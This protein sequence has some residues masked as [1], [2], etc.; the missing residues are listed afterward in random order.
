MNGWTVLG[1]FSFLILISFFLVFSLYN[2]VEREKKAFWRSALFLA[3]LVFVNFGLRL[4]EAPLQ[5]WLFGAVFTLFTF[6]LILLLVP[7]LKKRTVEIVGEPQKIDERDVI[8][9]RFDL[10]EGTE[11]FEGYYER[12]PEYKKIDDEIRKIPDILAS[13]HFDKN[14]EL[15]SLAA[16]EFDF[17]EQQ[18]TQVRGEV[19]ERMTRSSPAENTRLV[20]K[21]IKYLGGDICGV[22]LLDQAY[23]YSH[24]GRGPE[25]YGQKINV[26]H[27]YAIAF[28]LEMDLGMIAS[29]PRVPVIV[30]TGRKY[31]E[32]AKISITVA[33]LIR[34]LGFPARAHIAGSNYQVM[35]P[36]FG[37]KGGLGELGRLGILITEKYGP[38][39]RLGLI[40]TDFPLIPDAP[41]SL[42]IQEFCRKCQKCAR[43]CPA[44]AIPYGDKSEENGVLKWVLNREECYRFWRKAGTDCAVCISVCPFSKPDNSFHSLIRRVA[45]RSSFAQSF[46][47]RADDFFYGRSPRP[48]KSPLGI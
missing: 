15:F 1:E 40:T 11:S 43:N 10:A 3:G 18:L 46:S 28:A 37:W 14:P 38:R 44:Q 9:A 23:V 48:K 19:F 7:S 33:S 21:I 22:C 42:G 29:A 12:K 13:S 30:E 36:P 47:I 32:A 39:V 20:K 6:V 2:L 17:L 25:P 34:R 31:V 41:R 24:V 4:V 26:N 45:E 16:V 8:F 27:K 35:L 5:N